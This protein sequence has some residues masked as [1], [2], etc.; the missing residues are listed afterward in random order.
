MKRYYAI[1]IPA[2]GARPRVVDG[3]WSGRVRCARTKPGDVVLPMTIAYPDKPKQ[4]ENIEIA[5]PETEVELGDE[6]TQ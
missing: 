2:D 3:T 1:I 6:S 4:L 5:V